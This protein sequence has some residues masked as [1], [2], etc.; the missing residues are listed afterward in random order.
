MSK[1]NKERIYK[2]ST[3][4]GQ[5]L[6]EGTTDGRTQNYLQDQQKGG[7]AHSHFNNTEHLHFNN[8]LFQT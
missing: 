3:V 8:N 2:T 6:R 4:L 1:F 5:V 7:S